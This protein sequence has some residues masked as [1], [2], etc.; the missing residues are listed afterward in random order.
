M[1]NITL[2]LEFIKF[3]LLGIITDKNVLNDFFL[4]NEYPSDELMI[5]LTQTEIPKLRIDGLDHPDNAFSM[6]GVKRMNNLHQML[7]YVRE[8]KID[9]DLVETGVWKGGAT[10]FMKIYCDMYGLEK[11]IF[12]CDSFEGLPRPS[13]KFLSDVGDL[14]YTYD[15]LK[16]SLN[17]VMDNFRLFNCLDQNIV[18]IKGF[19][20]N[21]L[22][23]NKQINKLSLLRMDGDMYESTHDVFY[24]LYD[25]VS[26]DGVVIIDDYCLKGCR[27]CVLDFRNERK[28]NSELKTI[29]KCG[30]YWIKNV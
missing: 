7:D 17:N 21:T 23:N 19:F 6:I 14:H 15:N 29:D 1:N 9:G 30:V 13:G 24:S 11:K 28:I 3:C 8:N 25:K 18:F 27:D 20:S 4:T 12:V 5:R 16:V 10:I 26:H 2:K 22:P